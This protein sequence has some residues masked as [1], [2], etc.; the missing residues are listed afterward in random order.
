MAFDTYNDLKTSVASWLHRDDLTSIIPDLILLGEKWIFRHARTR[1]MESA[2]SR[3][4][5]SGVAAVPSGYLA[6][7]HLRADGSPASPLKVRPSSWIYEHYPLRSSDGKPKF[8]GVDGTDFVFGPFPDDT[9]TIK[10]VC[11][12]QPTSIQSSANAVYLANPDLYLYAALCAAEPHIKNDK[13]LPMWM[14]QRNSILADINGQDKD[15]QY[16]P[17]M[18]VQVE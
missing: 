12:V 5:A 18:A 3:A 17:G 13:R 2:Y 6:I 7:K 11:Y 14:E 1:D 16:G 9:Y 8:V 15:S 4:I 10:G